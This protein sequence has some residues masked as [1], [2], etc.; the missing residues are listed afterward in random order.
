M[1]GPGNKARCKKTNGVVR[2]KK[3]GYKWENFEA[4]E[5]PVEKGKPVDLTPP[6]PHFLKVKDYYHES[7]FYDF[8][9]IENATTEF[10]RLN[11]E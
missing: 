6:T 4:T 11:K 1:N 5:S 2:E 8:H 3:W 10:G 7:R 9:G